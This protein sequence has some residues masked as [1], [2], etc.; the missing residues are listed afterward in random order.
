[1]TLEE[2]WQAQLD[3]LRQEGRYRTLSK[4]RGIDF[5][6][7]DYLGYG[8]ELWA[9]VDELSRS[10]QASRLLRGQH[11]IW[12]EVEA[13]LADWHGAEAALMMTSGYVANEGL[14]STIIEP[15]DWVAFG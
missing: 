11:E 8:K 4:P 10:G 3:A 14:L 7:N 5:S 13:R 15:Q 2:R 6:S 1:M 12:Q 9:N